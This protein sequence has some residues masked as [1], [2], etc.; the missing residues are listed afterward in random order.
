MVSLVSDRHAAKVNSRGEER[1]ATHLTD[2]YISAI[3]TCQ[4]GLRLIKINSLSAVISPSPPSLNEFL[5][6]FILPQKHQ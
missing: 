6:V 3:S 2:T 4:N 5:S 1:Q